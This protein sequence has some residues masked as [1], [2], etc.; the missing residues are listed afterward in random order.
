LRD[1]ATLGVTTLDRGLSWDGLQAL[2]VRAQPGAA[3]PATNAERLEWAT[4]ALH[5][6]RYG[7]ANSLASLVLKNS[8]TR[9][10]RE[11]ALMIQ[12]EA[13]YPEERS[14]QQREK[15][16]SVLGDLVAAGAPNVAWSWIGL[17]SPYDLAKQTRRRRPPRSGTHEDP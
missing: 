4:E 5:T 11:T 7:D 14:A 8:P 10:N 15:A 1:L 12:A 2:F 9:A 16:I 17:D 13:Y 6:H 3:I